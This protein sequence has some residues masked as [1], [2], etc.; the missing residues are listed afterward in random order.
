VIVER[1][2]RTTRENARLSKPLLDERG[3]RSVWLVTQP[4]HCRRSARLFRRAGFDARAWHIADSLQYR[5]RWRTLRW[6]IREY[7]AW[8]RLFV[9]PG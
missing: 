7:A 6:V 9:G 2:S 4:F 1:A 5:E 8:V 3:V